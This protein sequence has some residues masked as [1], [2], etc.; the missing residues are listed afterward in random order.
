MT[1]G[2][3]NYLHHPK[4]SLILITINIPEEVFNNVIY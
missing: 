1:L 2:T 3:Y 4:R